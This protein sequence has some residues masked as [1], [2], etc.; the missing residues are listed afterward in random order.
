M[1]TRAPISP[2]PSLPAL[3]TLVALF[4]LSGCGD[5]PTDPAPAPEPG[6]IEGFLFVDGNRNAARDE[7]E[8]TLQGLTV[9][10][11]APSGETRAVR[12]DPV[13]SYAF[14]ELAP[15]A[16]TVTGA[17]AVGWTN[18]TP[19][20]VRV[21]VAPAETAS[22]DFGLFQDDAGGA[23]FT[24]IGGEVYRDLNANGLRDDGEPGLEGIEVWLCPAGAPE[25]DGSDPQ[26]CCAHS[27]SRDAGNY[28][29]GNLFA[30]EY[31]AKIRDLGTW[32]VSSEARVQVVV[33]DGDV[34]DDVSF[35]LV[36]VE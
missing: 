5:D 3:V 6:S 20:E 22:A 1:S 21:E 24:A 29:F 17:T 12:T 16:Y 9:R 19:A 26:L 32:S 35:G 15:G 7:G 14:D 25:H 27:L 4:A 10:L 11:T 8:F 34:V 31:F 2:R 13:G 23:E 33:E 18:T 30:G 36:P 28:Q